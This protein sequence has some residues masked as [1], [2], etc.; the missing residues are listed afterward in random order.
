VTTN[1]SATCS[2][3]EP[4]LATDAR[5]PLRSGAGEKARCSLSLQRFDQMQS[6][7]CSECRHPVGE[8]P[9]L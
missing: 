9:S 7:R 4:A 2:N 6:Q 8:S 5:L 1:V 3:S